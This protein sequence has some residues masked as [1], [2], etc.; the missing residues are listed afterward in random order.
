MA[1]FRLVL[2]LHA[3]VILPVVPPR[4]DTLLMEGTRRL[5]Q[6]WD[7]PHE[8]PLTFDDKLQGYCASQLVFVSTPDHPL[9]AKQIG[10][11]TKMLSS[12]L[13]LVKKLPARLRQ[14]GGQDAQRLTQ[15]QAIVAPYAYFYGHG[16]AY[17]CLKR[18]SLI[19]AMG[20]EHK[21]H[22]GAFTVAAVETITDQH[23]A[24]RPWPAAQGRHAATLVASEWIDDRQSTVIGGAHQAVV[25]PPRVVKEV[26]YA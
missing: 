15:H 24:L 21:R 22:F 11:S 9:R 17:E 2:A 6:D 26:R 1:C 10:L 4:L 20:R 3:P 18:L 5:M 7:T 13:T 12:D 8:L 14:D 25:R 23:W 19:R 16:D